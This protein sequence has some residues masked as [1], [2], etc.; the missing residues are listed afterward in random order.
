MYESISLGPLLL[1]PSKPVMFCWLTSMPNKRRTPDEIY[2]VRVEV[3]A[4][5]SV[6]DF[7][8]Q[9][10]VCIDQLNSYLVGP[11]PESIV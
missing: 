10:L 9:M 2:C 7:H 3:P 4:D 6:G 1:H 5:S 8:Q 11:P